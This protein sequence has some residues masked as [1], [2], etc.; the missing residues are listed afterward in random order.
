MKPTMKTS[1]FIYASIISLP[2]MLISCHSP[3]KIFQREVAELQATV[4]ASEERITLESMAHLP[5]PVQ[6]YFLHCGLVGTPL[7]NHAEVVFRESLKE[8]KFH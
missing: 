4:V 3:K 5:E 1:A 7:S 8:I 2:M 6:R